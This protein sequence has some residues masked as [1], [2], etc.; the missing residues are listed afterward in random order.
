MAGGRGPCRVI[1]HLSLM[2]LT[3]HSQTKVW[4]VTYMCCFS[5][6]LLLH[7][8][9]FFLHSLLKMYQCDLHNYCLTAQQQS[10]MLP[11]KP[12]LNTAQ[13]L[14]L[15]DLLTAC[16]TTP[17]FSLPLVLNRHILSFLVSP[18]PA[19]LPSQ[20]E[21][22][23]RFLAYSIQVGASEAYYMLNLWIDTYFLI[24]SSC[25]NCYSNISFSQKAMLTL[26]NILPPHNILSTLYL[27]ELL[28]PRL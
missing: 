9:F 6:F 25:L 21:R 24:P 15:L 3:H 5:C 14:S 19:P 4:R 20:G 22:D 18:S 26:L 11:W 7:S 12:N 17:S 28:S 1:H 23:C 2:F 13:S 10:S 8:L 16:C 27:L